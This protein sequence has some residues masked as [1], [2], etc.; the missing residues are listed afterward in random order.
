MM[1]L[2]ALLALLGA[3]PAPNDITAAATCALPRAETEAAF[4]AL[5]LLGTE[6]DTEADERGTL[7]SFTG[8]ELWG[9]ASRHIRLSDYAN[10]VAGTYS[11]SFE[12]APADDFATVRTR[13][14]A[15]HGKAA[16]DRATTSACELRLAPDG[17]WSRTLTVADSGGERLLVCTFSK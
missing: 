10:P 14:L 15:V 7:Y 17:A 5:P 13:L 16:C 6:D 8:G 2:L 1:R 4:K 3:A 12:T 9:H 11:Q